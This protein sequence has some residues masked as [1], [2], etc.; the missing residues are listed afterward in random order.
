MQLAELNIG[1]LI[2]PTSDPRVAEFIDNIARINGLGKRMPGF[3][4]IMEGATGQGNTATAINDDPQYIPN[5][6]VWE[7]A[8]ALETFVFK[9]LHAK[10]LGRRHEWFEVMGKMQFVMW[11]VRDGHQPSLAEALEKL[12]LLQQHGESAQAFGWRYLRANPF[13]PHAQTR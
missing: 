1:R 9:T 6:T 13:P 8:E 5:M 12:S 2:A 11:W 3:V 4:W 10:F 7:S